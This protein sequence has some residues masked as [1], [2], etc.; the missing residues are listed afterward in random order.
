MNVQ[1]IGEFGLIEA[2]KQGVRPSKDVIVGIGDDA[3]VLPYSNTHHLLFATDMSVEGVHFTTRM[4]PQEI[5]RKALARNISDIAAMGGVPTHV[6][7][8]LGLPPQSKALWVKNMYQGMSALANMF[9]VRI[10]GGD[11]TKAPAITINV[12]IIGK[13]LK[14]HCVTRAGA[15]PGDWIFVTG[16]LGG[17]FKSGKHL[18]FT[19]RLDQ[20]QFL[21]RKFKPNA[22]MD[23]SDGLAGDLNHI[24]NASRVGAVLDEDLIPRP[25][26][27]S[28]R[29]VYSEG[30][31]FEL[32][33]TLPAEHARRLMAYQERKKGLFF[34]PIGVITAD[35][36]QVIQAKGYTHF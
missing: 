27:V 1:K 10:V 24:L 34:Y 33:F 29:Q 25:K 16:L 12:A 17:S 19:P 2:I 31:D 23:I 32:L 8:S 13:V 22:M 11:T 28:L 20:A 18:T 30:E 7:V 36:A 21:V 3:A 5:G 6:V 35:P 4:K 26:G 14:R 15:K 9:D